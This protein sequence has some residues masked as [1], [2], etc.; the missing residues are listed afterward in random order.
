VC[1]FERETEG[2]G[3]GEREGEPQGTCGA[4][5]VVGEACADTAECD[6]IPDDDENP[7]TACGLA[8][9]WMLMPAD[10]LACDPAVDVC[11][12]GCSV[13]RPSTGTLHTS[14]QD[15]GAIGDACTTTNHC[16]HNLVVNRGLA[17]L[18]GRERPRRRQPTRATKERAAR[19][20]A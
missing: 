18:F 8:G 3:E 10:A 6:P 17:F 9:S 5:A 20:P 15:C 13:C 4:L 11:A 19:H 7:T 12:G 1:E 14:C 2:E 16:R